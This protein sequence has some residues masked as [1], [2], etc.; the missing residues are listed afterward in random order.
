M[1]PTE[2]ARWERIHH[3]HSCLVLNPEKESQTY[4]AQH[5]NLE[6]P[7]PQHVKVLRQVP[8]LGGV[9]ALQIDDAAHAQP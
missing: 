8:E 4:V 5:K 1:R 6:G 3:P 7:A 9:V 2:L